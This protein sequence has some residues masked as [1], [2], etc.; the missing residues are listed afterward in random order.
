VITT[1]LL[2]VLVVLFLMGLFSPFETFGWWAGWYGEKPGERYLPDPDEVP[3]TEA[4]QFV[5][6]LTGING[7]NPEEFTESEQVFLKALQ[8]RLPEIELVD[9]F[10]PYAASNQAPTGERFFGWFW[11]RLGNLRGRG[12][13]GLISYLIHVRNI[14][15]VLVSSDSRFG[16][17]YNYATAQRVLEKLLAHGYP[18]G[19]GTPIT[20]I[21]YS[22]GGQVS[23][24][25]APL[26]E[27]AA[28]APVYVISLGGVISSNRHVLEL[29]SLTHLYGSKDI[30]QRLGYIF[31]P[32]RWP[33]MRWTAWNK[34]RR[35]GIIKRVFTG[36]MVHVGAG[37]YM[38]ADAK[39]E[40]GQSYLDKTL[41]VMTGLIRG[42]ETGVA[43]K[44]ERKVQKVL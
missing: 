2:S 8:A 42:V 25:T 38:D 16:P 24:G 35:A 14:W 12:A 37:D 6:Y 17:L 9:D 41:E 43:A 18:L 10:Y 19:S 31:F 15:Q 27:E 40:S 7:L 22:G 4:A 1:L 21:G 33:F 28:G 30:V 26:L 44:A 36:P 39:L 34:A 20:L 3:Q 11:R 29:E 5:V 32:R 23:V 13:L